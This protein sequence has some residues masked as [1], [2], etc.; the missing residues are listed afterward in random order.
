MV[1]TTKGDGCHLKQV[2]NIISQKQNNLLFCYKAQT[3]FSS[4]GDPTKAKNP[5]MIYKYPKKG[6]LDSK[7]H[8]GVPQNDN[9]LSQLLS[10]LPISLTV[11]TE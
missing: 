10:H 1:S 9:S 6:S 3:N 7:V 11:A 4:G 2:T 8:F 5:Q